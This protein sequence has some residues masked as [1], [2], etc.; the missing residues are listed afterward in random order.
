MNYNNWLFSYNKGCHKDKV[1]LKS[2]LNH[3][4]INI[5]YL[6]TWSVVPNGP[7]RASQGTSA[8]GQSR[9]L[10]LVSSS[11][12]Q[13]LCSCALSCLYRARKRVVLSMFFSSAGIAFH[14][15]ITKIVKKFL[16]TSRRLVFTT[17]FRGPAAQQEAHAQHLEPDPWSQAALPVHYLVYHG[18]ICLMPS[19]L[20]C[21]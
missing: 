10:F 7:G 15:P 9:T 21:G 2:S 3:W 17:M 1:T 6:F 11:S 16:R 14:F 4:L 13:A 8:P 19:L 12:H 18:H 20:Q 5:T